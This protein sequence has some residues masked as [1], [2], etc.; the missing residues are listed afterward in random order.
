MILLIFY[1]S[2]DTYYFGR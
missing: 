1:V 2:L